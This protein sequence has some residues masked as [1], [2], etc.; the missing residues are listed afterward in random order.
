MY[1]VSKN[2]TWRHESSDIRETQKISHL[3]TK[4]KIIGAFADWTHYAVIL[5]FFF[6]RV[7]RA[8]YIC[9]VV[10]FPE[11]V[12]FRCLRSCWISALSMS[13][14]HVLS[15]LVDMYTHGGGVSRHSLLMRSPR[16]ACIFISRQS[17]YT[18]YV[19]WSVSQRFHC[20]AN[21]C[22]KES[23]NNYLVFNV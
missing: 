9:N 13:G 4:L 11:R 3:S 18:G 23:Y 15:R 19:P 21:A 10:L 14:E 20:A 22:E 1:C 16:Y 7:T 12:A 2:N 6:L 8:S 5:F 17:G